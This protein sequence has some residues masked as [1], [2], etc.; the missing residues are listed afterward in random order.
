[1]VA[2]GWYL[3]RKIFALFHRSA[4]RKPQQGVYDG[5]EEG[6]VWEGK[7]SEG[8]GREGQGPRLP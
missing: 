3:R 6:N 1:M 8:N 7:N 2:A 5:T 4:N